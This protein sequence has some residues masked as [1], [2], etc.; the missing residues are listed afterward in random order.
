MECR[1]RVLAALNLEEPDRVPTHVIAIDGNNV[2]KV[3]GKPKM[4]DFEL[5]DYVKSTNPD[6][7]VD[8][9]NS[10]LESIVTTVFTKMVEA[11]AKIGLDMIQ[12]GILPY[13]FESESQLSDIFG[14]MWDLKDNNGNFYPDYT[15][16]TLNSIEKWEAKKKEMYDV[17]IPKYSKLSNKMF[18]RINKK[19]K[20]KIFVISTN[21]FVGIFESTWQGMGLDFF[22]RQLHK[23]PS[24]I[25][26][27]YDVYA[28]FN[29]ALNDASIKAGSEVII[30]A[31]DLAYKTAPFMSPKK[32]NELLKPAYQKLVDAA[33]ERGAKIVLH[34]DGY[35]HPLLDFIVD[36]GFDGLHALEPSANVDMALVK[37]KV[38]NKLCLLGN[39]DITHV[40]TAEG[41]QKDVDNWVNNA[42]KQAGQG[43]GYIC[44]ATNMHP[45]VEPQNLMWMVEACK[46]YGTYP[47]K[48]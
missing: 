8:V 11:A 17:L 10:T 12:V 13:K 16:G 28:D 30:E 32:F 24:L 47:L 31:G 2:D 6:D 1:E 15:H 36:C 14:R 19:Y 5:I 3:L 41:T 35:I 46:K 27:V 40:L 43:G 18:R 45:G 38:G 33:H 9:I 7:F 20:D 42:I 21:D 22:T 29:I 37:K 34:T 23:N 26:D 4:T 48:I 44:S 25:E 39:V